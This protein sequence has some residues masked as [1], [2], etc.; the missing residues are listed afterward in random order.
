MLGPIPAPANPQDTDI[1]DVC[2][3]VLLL[4]SAHTVGR[5]QNAT[6]CSLCLDYLRA[7]RKKMKLVKL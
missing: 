2:F 7:M 1:I 3:K 6:M 4:L 5:K